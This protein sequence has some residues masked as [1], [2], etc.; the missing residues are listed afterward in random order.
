MGNFFESSLN[1]F[2]IHKD[3]FF[4]SPLPLQ[5]IKMMGV[6]DAMMPRSMQKS[7]KCMTGS[8]VVEYPPKSTYNMDTCLQAIRM[9]R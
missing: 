3:Y 1:V 5:L 6:L 8:N 9:W 7:A 2:C 4:I